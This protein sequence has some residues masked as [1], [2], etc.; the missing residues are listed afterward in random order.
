MTSNA[1]VVIAPNHGQKYDLS[2]EPATCSVLING[3]PASGILVCAKAG[4]VLDFSFLIERASP[5][6]ESFVGCTLIGQFNH[7]QGTSQASIQ[8]NI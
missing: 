2:G 7:L 1:C 5:K 4:S 3:E 8:I 6:N